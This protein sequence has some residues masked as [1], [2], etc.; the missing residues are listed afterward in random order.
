MQQDEIHRAKVQAF[1]AAITEGLN[2]GEPTSLDMDS[3]IA[4][5]KSSVH[6]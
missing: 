1:Q 5:A 3:I 2:S 6:A 4:E